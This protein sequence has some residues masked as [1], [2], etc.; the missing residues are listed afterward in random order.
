MGSCDH[1]HNLS[2]LPAMSDTNKKRKDKETTCRTEFYLL[3]SKLF[4]CHHCPMC[5][6]L[7]KLIVMKL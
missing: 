5:L 7:G 6:R 1:D 2:D 3:S 4:N